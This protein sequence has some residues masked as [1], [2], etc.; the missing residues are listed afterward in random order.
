MRIFFSILFVRK[1]YGVDQMLYVRQLKEKPSQTRIDQL[2]NVA[3]QQEIFAYFES[4]DTKTKWI[5]VGSTS[6]IYPDKSNDRIQEVDDWYQKL[7]KQFPSKIDLND[8][9]ILGGF[10]FDQRSGH[11]MWGPWS[12]GIF[13]LPRII[14]KITDQKIIITEIKAHQ[15]SEQSLADTLDEMVLMAHNKQDLTDFSIEDLD[16]NWDQQVDDLAMT[17]RK[18]NILKKVVLGRYKQGKI[19]GG[20]DP[21]A[22]ISALRKFDQTTYHFII[23]IKDQTFISATPERLFML[24]GND[25]STAAV[26]GTIGRGQNELA[27]N[28]LALQLFNDA[29]NRSEH[30][31]VVQEIT[32]RMKNFTSDMSFDKTPMIIKNLTVQHL[33]TPITAKID[34]Q[35]N[36]FQLLKYM[37]PTPA[38]GGLPTNEAIKIIQEMEARAR[39]LFGAPIGYITF[40]GDSEMIVGIRSMYLRLDQ[41]LMF[42]GA[43]IMPDSVGTEEFKETELKFKPMI[44]LLEYLKGQTNE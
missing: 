33:Y 32:Q 21:V 40:S 6:R 14:I 23:K 18:S 30:Q 20:F 36:V 44:K 8:I 27:D 38:L 31:I 4:N 35:T 10:S 24:N 9:A 11:G 42:A 34:D 2:I 5:G 26:A 13:I 3:L 22:A 12:S 28:K 29:K 25:F 16:E 1:T 37:H 41:F 7:K 39:V 15:F 17:I 43:G 19:D